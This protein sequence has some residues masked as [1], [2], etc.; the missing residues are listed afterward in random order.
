MTFMRLIINTDILLTGGK[1]HFR[2]WMKFTNLFWS[3]K[4]L[5]AP[6][7]HIFIGS[8]TIRMYPSVQKKTKQYFWEQN[9]Q[10]SSLLDKDILS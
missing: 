5:V 1:S 6:S 7:L 10:I 8:G 9:S 4:S 2:V 3:L